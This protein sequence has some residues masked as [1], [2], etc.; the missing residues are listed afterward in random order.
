MTINAEWHRAHV[1]GAHAS[2]DD[3]VA[4]HRLHEQ[5]CN[6][7]SM[8]ESIRAEIRRREARQDSE[9]DHS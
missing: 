4:W 7:R 3:R 5:A 9:E 8:P 6:C 1:L 2:L